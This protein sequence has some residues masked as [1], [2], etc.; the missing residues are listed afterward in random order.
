[1]PTACWPDARASAWSTRRPSEEIAEAGT[2]VDQKLAERIAQVRPA[3]GPHQARS[4]RSEIEYLSADGEEDFTI[5]QANARARRE[6]SLRGGSRLG[7]ARPRILD[8]DRST[9]STTWMS[10]RS[11]SFRVATALIPFLEHDDANRA[12]MGANMQRQ[13]VPLLRPDAPIVGTGMEYQAA[14]DSGQVVVARESGTRGRA[15]TG[16]DRRDAGRRGR[17]A[18]STRCTSSAA[19]TRTPASTSGRSC[20]MGDSGDA[21]ARSSPTPPRPR[22]ANW[23]WARTCSWRSCRW[24]GGNFEDAI[25]AQRAAGARGRLHLDPHREVR[26]RGARHQAGAGGDHARHPERRRGQP[27]GPGR[28]RHHPRRRGGAAERHSRRQDHAERRDRTLSA[29]ERLLRAIFGEKAREV[30]D[31]SA[32]RAARR[33]RQG[34]RCQGVPPREQR[35]AAGRGQP[36]GARAR[37]P[38]S[39]RSARATRWPAATA[40][41]A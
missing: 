38:R 10:R 8:R 32:A 26:D 3:H 25:L 31:T 24:E 20:T 36:D 14:R 29:E 30:K 19:R 40:T 22:T 23:P 4:S 33:A 12:L 37:S 1:M 27:G 17:G 39:A 21:G 6:L 15:W 35:R 28:A 11:R 5:A 2:V 34:H 18:R 16:G 13:A 9:G 41:R 7:A